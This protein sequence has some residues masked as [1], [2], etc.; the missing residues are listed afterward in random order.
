MRKY[1]ERKKEQE[2]SLK[3]QMK[4]YREQEE[5][6][7]ARIRQLE[8]EVRRRDEG[9]AG[10]HVIKTELEYIPSVAPTNGL[11]VTLP[12]SSSEK[13]LLA[14]QQE[15]LRQQQEA[16]S[17]QQSIIAQQQHIIN[18]H[19]LGHLAPA[20]LQRQCQF[21]VDYSAF[22]APTAAVAALAAL[23]EPS[24]KLP[25]SIA[26]IQGPHS[27]L[28]ATP[29]PPIATVATPQPPAL[30][31]AFPPRGPRRNSLLHLTRAATQEEPLFSGSDCLL[32][33]EERE[34]AT[35]ARQEHQELGQRSSGSYGQTGSAPSSPNDNRMAITH[36][37]APPDM[38]AV[39][40]V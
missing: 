10:R 36:L 4:Q 20:H 29:L 21:L 40:C 25:P 1:R 34:A 17:V 12:M 3:T 39:S 38:C 33:L 30:H 35:T 15:V 26:D 24:S 23:G 7:R 19:N 13:N 31:S 6:Y 8:E 32:P 2:Q 37:L 5:F 14:Q 18:Q 11:K 22:N 27:S 28:L 16:I 9:N